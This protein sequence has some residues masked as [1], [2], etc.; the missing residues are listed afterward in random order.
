MN[1]IRKRTR[2]AEIRNLSG[3]TGSQF[4]MITKHLNP[5]VRIMT[6]YSHLINI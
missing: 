5:K 4:Y 1:I 3:E 6:Y 2:N